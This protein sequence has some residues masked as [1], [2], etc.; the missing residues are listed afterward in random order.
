MSKLVTGDGRT[1]IESKLMRES[2]VDKRV[3][4]RTDSE[5]ELEILPD[6]I[7]VSVG[8][9][10]IFDRGKEAVLPIVD[11]IAKAR[12][13]HRMIVGVGGGTRVTYRL[14]ADPNGRQPAMLARSA[15][16]GSVKKLLDEVRSEIL[17]R[18]AR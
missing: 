2:L 3:I 16:K 11:E 13:K 10:S 15:I 6:V 4:A 12:G 17:A 8:G 1:H 14:K 9:Q 18:A 7:L 5:H